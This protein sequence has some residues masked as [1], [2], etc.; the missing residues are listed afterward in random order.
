MRKMKR[1][2]SGDESEVRDTKWGLIWDSTFVA[3][4]AAATIRCGDVHRS[5]LGL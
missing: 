5:F 1:I 2:K 3:G 4:G